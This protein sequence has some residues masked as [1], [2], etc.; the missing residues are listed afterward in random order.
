MRVAICT[1]FK[2]QLISVSAI[3]H[4]IMRS[5]KFRS[6]LKFN[7]PVLLLQQPVSYQHL[8]FHFVH[9]SLMRVPLILITTAGISAYLPSGLKRYNKEGKHKVTATCTNYPSI[10]PL[11]GGCWEKYGRHARVSALWNKREKPGSRDC[12]TKLGRIEHRA[13]IREDKWV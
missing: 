7:Y 11:S 9:T 12:E 6:F 2:Y 8:G 5:P 1:S 10:H 3:A 4:Y 13:G